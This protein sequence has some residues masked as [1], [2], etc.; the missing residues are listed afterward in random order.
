ME[1]IPKI[2]YDDEPPVWN[3]HPEARM[4]AEAIELPDTEDIVELARAAIPA[5]V[6]RAV[7]LANVSDNLNAVVGVLNSL[8][9]RAY[10]KPMQEVRGEHQL[11]LIVHTGVNSG[12]VVLPVIDHALPED[13][14]SGAL[15]S[16]GGDI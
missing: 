3:A 9:D 11:Q 1:H 4:T 6:R 5:L 8:A 10:G 2:N 14:A 16:S 15:L 7:M 13:E 12:P